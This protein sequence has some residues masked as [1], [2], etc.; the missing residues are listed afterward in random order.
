MGTT[1]MPALNLNFLPPI[2]KLPMLHPTTRPLQRI[3]SQTKMSAP[4]RSL[5]PF[6]LFVISALFVVK[7]SEP[8]R[9]CKK[10]TKSACQENLLSLIFCLK[11]RDFQ[12]A[13]SRISTRYYFSF[14]FPL[15]NFLNSG[16]SFHSTKYG[17]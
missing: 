9:G 12:P 10:N 14:L 5:F 3:N 6:S 15:M 11:I 17:A 2:G 4:R 16:R 1:F 7:K 13:P 8:I